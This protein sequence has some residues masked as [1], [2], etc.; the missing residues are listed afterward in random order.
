MARKMRRSNNTNLQEKV[1]RDAR[2]KH[3]L[4][5]PNPPQEDKRTESGFSVSSIIKKNLAGL[6][7]KAKR[8]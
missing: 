6:R 4:A 3:A 1:V 2:L 7:T 8:Q 5:N